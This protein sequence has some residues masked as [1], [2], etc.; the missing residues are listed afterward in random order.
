M[1]IPSGSLGL[2]GKPKDFWAWPHRI[3]SLFSA[4][5]VPS[6]CVN[7]TALLQSIR[8]FLVITNDE[9]FSLIPPELLILLHT[10]SNFKSKVKAIVIFSCFSHL[11]PSFNVLWH[12]FQIRNAKAD[13]CNSLLSLYFLPSLFQ[14]TEGEETVEIQQN[15]KI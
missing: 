6:S 5:S 7:S 1:T 4:A 3:C 11:V 10:C 12:A 15:L 2:L 14:R 9:M 8:I 13:S